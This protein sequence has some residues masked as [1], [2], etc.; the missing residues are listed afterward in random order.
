VEVVSD[1]VFDAVELLGMWVDRDRLYLA[2]M[3]DSPEDDPGD[4]IM[5]QLKVFEIIDR[6]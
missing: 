5:D 6:S 2:K 3:M 1:R 4:L